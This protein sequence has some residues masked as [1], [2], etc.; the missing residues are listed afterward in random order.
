VPA[1]NA[2]DDLL[3]A[4]TDGLSFS[5]WSNLHVDGPLNHAPVVM[6]PQPTVQATVGPTLM[7]SLFSVTDAENDTLTYVFYDATPGGGHFEK[8]GVAQAANQIFTATAAELANTTFVPG[9]NASDNL[10]VGAND[11][12]TFSGWSNLHVDGPLNH[13][14]VV[15]V[16]NPIVQAMVGQTLQMANLF[17]V[18]DAENDTLTYVFYDATAGGGH[19]EKNGVAQA[20]NQIFTATAAELANTTFVPDVNAADNLLVGAND[21]HTFSGWSNLHVD[22]PANHAAVVTVPDPTVQATAG[23]TFLMSDLFSVTDA[24]NDTL[25]YVFYDA[26]LGGGH[27]EKNG[28]AQSPNQIFTATAADLANTTFVVGQNG[29]DDLLVGANDGHVF[30]GWSNLKIEGP[31]NHAPVV[32]VPQATVDATPGQTL[33]MSTLFNVTDVDN[34]PLAYVFYD[35]TPGG[36]HFEVNG[37]TQA[38][39]Q[40]FGVSAANLANTTFVAGQNGTDDL[41]VGATDFLSFSGWSNLH[42]V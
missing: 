26:T 1:A 2:S 34:G 6:V 22:G 3:V 41:L 37:V 11:G 23:Q 7:S 42:I 38:A 10:L 25:T 8:N 33:Q 19:F 36:G 29:T 28:V 35:A 4:A 27:F 14:P 15:M 39:G 9:A 12:H 24:E 32:N 5:G 21:G 30:S 40:I 18:T 20:A 17:S 16:P 13:A 31:E